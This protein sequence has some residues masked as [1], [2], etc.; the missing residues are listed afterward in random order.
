M[1]TDRDPYDSSTFDIR[2]FTLTA[3][4]TL[5]AEL[6]LAPFDAAP[7]SPDEL[8]LLRH[9][10]RLES[11][12]ME[13]LRNLLVTA[14]HKDARVT[15]FL[16]TWAF[17]K[18]WIADAVDAVLEANGEPRLKDVEEG[19]RRHSPAEAVERR[20][21]ITRAIEAIGRGVPIVAV[22]MT[23]GLVD[24]WVMRHAY[25]VLVERADSPAL[26]AVVERLRTV[27][28]RH[29]EFF[30]VEARWRLEDSARAVKQTRASLSTAVWPLG[31]V[32]RSDAE[33]T[34]FD[35]AVWGGAAGH[36]RA[37]AVGD[38]VASLPGLDASVG[39]AVTRKL[40]A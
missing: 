32:E 10:G 29:E 40:T 31:A 5:R 30:D 17:E 4:G 34:F 20:G 14:T 28:A 19:P 38:R 9:L 24:E 15:A 36:L 37:D 27:K 23:T 21:P 18:Y 6:D 16:V 13:H 2:E 25:D 7:L 26:T 1:T 12:T 11:A 35:A 33:R 3:Q 8:R 22:H 39:A